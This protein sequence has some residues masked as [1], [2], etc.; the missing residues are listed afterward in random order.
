MALTQPVRYSVTLEDEWGIEASTVAYGLVDPTA[1]MAQLQTAWFHFQQD[2][3]HLSDAKVLRGSIAII[4]APDSVKTA[5]A[6][7]SRV[8]SVAS[9]NF[10]G[11]ASPR[12]WGA[13][14]PAFAASKLSGDRINL[15]DG[16]VSSFVTLLTSVVSGVDAF[17]NDRSQQL[18]A[19]ADAFLS[20]RR[21]RR[22]LQRSSFEV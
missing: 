6:S 14:V 2:L 9:F 5:A 18:T 12:R 19:L 22:Q 4:M 7:G 11:T 8:E 15:A 3:D 1:T 16:D 20:V 13:V 21:K 10:I 17:A